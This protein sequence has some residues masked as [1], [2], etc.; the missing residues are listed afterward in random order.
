M[1]STTDSQDANTYHVAFPPD[2]DETA[3][4]TAEISHHEAWD[5]YQDGLAAALD[6]KRATAEQ[7]LRASLALDADNHQAW[8]WLAGI[9]KSPEESIRYLQRVLELV[10]DDPHALEGLEWAR[11]RLEQQAATAGSMLPGVVVSPTGTDGRERTEMRASRPV[12]S[13]VTAQTSRLVWIAVIVG[14]MLLACAMALGVWLAL[15]RGATSLPGDPNDS[16]VPMT[17]TAVIIAPTQPSIA[18][19]HPAERREI[20]S[21]REAEAALDT[22]AP[23]QDALSLPA[24]IITERTPLSPALPTLMRSSHASR[25]AGGFRPAW[26]SDGSP[27]AFVRPSD[28]RTLAGLWPNRV[29]ESDVEQIVERPRKW[30]DVDISE[31][32]LRA[33]EDERVVLDAKVSTGPATAPTV[34]GTFHILRKY[35]AIDMWGSDYYVPAV[36]YVMFFHDGY[37]IHGADWHDRFGQ[38]TGHGCVNMRPEDARKLFEWTAPR[39]KADAQSAMA[40]PLEQGTTVVIHE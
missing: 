21:L 3:S 23:P 5:L 22:E 40:T 15:N 28:W 16:A 25:L 24:P 6:G 13:S 11:Q 34:Q 32:T 33:F 1:V 35:R 38:P 17:P 27:L 20:L 18:V 8:F 29:Y 7:L 10:P 2:D 4:P 37:A 14:L 12:V 19:F 30:I 26:Y 39:L 9:V 31:Q 36:P